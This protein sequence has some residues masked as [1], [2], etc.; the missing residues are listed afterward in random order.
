MKFIPRPFAFFTAINFLLAFCLFKL[1]V[2]P[3]TGWLIFTLYSGEY[4]SKVMESYLIGKPHKYPDH[5]VSVGIVLLSI[6]VFAELLEIKDLI[7]LVIGL[8]GY[9]IAKVVLNFVSVIYQLK[10]HWHWINPTHTD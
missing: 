6:F 2:S 5:L 10:S 4:I 8:A 9:L 3:L 7:I 1:D